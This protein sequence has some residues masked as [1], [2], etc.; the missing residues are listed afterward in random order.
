MAGTEVLVRGTRRGKE[1]GVAAR[2][3]AGQSRGFF[4]NSGWALALAGRRGRGWRLG[5][6]TGPL[7]LP[8][9]AVASGLITAACLTV[10]GGPVA[11]RGVPP[12][13]AAGG[14]PA[15][16]AAVPCLGPP[17]QEPALAALEQAAA[18]AGVP[19]PRARRQGQRLTHGRWG[20]RLSLAH[21]RDCSRA[22]RRR[23]GD[24]PRRQLVAPTRTNL[25]SAIQ[26]HAPGNVLG[27]GRRCHKET[28]REKGEPKPRSANRGVAQPALREWLTSW[29]RAT[30]VWALWRPVGWQNLRVGA[31]IVISL[32]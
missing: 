30:R 21:G 1:R 15:G 6:E 18:A 27:P 22:V 28:G 2:A 4:G 24:A 5:I 32:L 31:V 17:G 26:R 8:A 10:G 20:W 16:G 14:V 3:V 23:G 25:S 7:L 12:P 11:L 29:P 9:A 19:T 13:P